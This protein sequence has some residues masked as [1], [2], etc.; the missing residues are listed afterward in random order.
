MK[1]QKFSKTQACPTCKSTEIYRLK[2]VGLAMRVVCGVS[3]YRPHW[4]S[5]C[6]T[7]FF[8]PRRAKTV[9]IEGQYEATKQ[10]QTDTN[11]PREAGLPH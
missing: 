6:D 2:R 10:A 11:P 7:F 5:N 9:K 8:A 4:C 3:N 1:F